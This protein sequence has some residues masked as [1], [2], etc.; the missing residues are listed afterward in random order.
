VNADCITV[1][2]VYALPERQ[3][4][5]S[6]RVPANSTLREAL[7]M[8]GL[9]ARHPE[10]DLAAVKVGI[11]GTVA[12]PETRL[13]DGDRIEVYRPLEVDPK[14]ARRDRAQRRR[15]SAG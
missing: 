5:L 7:Q 8:S 10:L 15:N 2:V 11:W 3:T 4:V 13:R 12:E 14:R 6:V 1:E 9:L